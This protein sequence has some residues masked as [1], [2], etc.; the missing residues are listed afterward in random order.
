MAKIKGVIPPM[1][2]PFKEN[3]DV[4]CDAFISNM[5]KWNNDKLAAYLVIGSNSETCYLKRRGKNWSL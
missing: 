4:D 5:Q 1:I 2:T 3:G